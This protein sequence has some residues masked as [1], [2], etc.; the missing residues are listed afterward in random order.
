MHPF[1]HILNLFYIDNCQHVY[2]AVGNF[3]NNNFIIY[4]KET[5]PQ[6]DANLEYVQF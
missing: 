2:I 5:S 3:A 6:F 4:L 1:L